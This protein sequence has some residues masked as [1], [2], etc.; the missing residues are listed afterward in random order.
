M[1]NIEADMR[2]RL[3]QLFIVLSEAS[4]D[5]EQSLLPSITESMLKVYNVFKT[6]RY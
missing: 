1:D 5:C 6:I 2:E 4:K 3:Q